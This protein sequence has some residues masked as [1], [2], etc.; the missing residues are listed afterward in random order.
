M[1]AE[2]TFAGPPLYGFPLEA[3][4]AAAMERDSTVAL[5]YLTSCVRRDGSQVSGGVRSVDL[6][7]SAL[8]GLGDLAGCSWYDVPCNAKVAANALA[9]KAKQAAHAV[10]SGVSG[11]G[12][13][14]AK[15]ATTSARAV[16]QA[17]T[18]IVK[19]AKQAGEY[20]ADAAQ[21]AAKAVVE[22]A[23]AAGRAVVSVGQALANSKLA[24]EALS[25]GLAIAVEALVCATGLVFLCGPSSIGA[26]QAGLSITVN[27]AMDAALG[28]AVDW[29]G[30]VIG[31]LTALIGFIIPG[32]APIVAPPGEIVVALKSAFATGS[33]SVI[34]DT[35]LVVI[36]SIGPMLTGLVRAGKADI[37]GD[38]AKS[39]QIKQAVAVIAAKPPAAVAQ[40][41]QAA[42]AKAIETK[43]SP[44]TKAAAEGLNTADA[45]IQVVN[46]TLPPAVIAAERQAAL[47]SGVPAASPSAVDRSSPYKKPSGVGMVI[48][49]AAGFLVL[50]PFGAAAGAAIGA[51]A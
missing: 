30:I 24:R 31:L 34:A 12:A 51:R 46:K 22:G 9:A 28:K 47:V 36:K 17:T 38:P 14:I 19:K 37:K 50:G 39:V 21:A 16:Q 6:R 1:L 26:L 11:A 41:A 42:T 25:W 29:A 43:V 2:I 44:T 27:L 35:V 49:G 13:A 45:A 7:S 10:A 5:G 8:S 23:K 33:K 20:V 48:G 18:V 4:I 15:A 3:C 32:G 40:V